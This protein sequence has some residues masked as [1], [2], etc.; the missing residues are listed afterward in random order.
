L[1]QQRKSEARICASR[2]YV[3]HKNIKVCAPVSTTILAMQLVGAED[4]PVDPAI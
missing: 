4:L 3:K 1:G 2:F